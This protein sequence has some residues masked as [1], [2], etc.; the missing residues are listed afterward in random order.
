L[1]GS[2]LPT[3]VLLFFLL[4]VVLLNAPLSRWAPRWAFG[5]GEMAVILGM[6]LVGCALPAVG[7][8]RHLPPSLTG[9]YHFAGLRVDYARVLEQM[10]LPAWL[11]PTT[12]AT[13]IAQRGNDPVVR[14]YVGRA[15]AG[16]DTFAAR[17]AAVPWQAWVVPC[18]A[19][20]IFLVGLFGSILCLMVI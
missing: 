9:I 11:F 2:F 13:E 15:I 18:I 17:V 16:D 10:D 3:G 12:T 1:V 5:G 4:F 7:L 19:W 6:M 14:D 20:G 8:M